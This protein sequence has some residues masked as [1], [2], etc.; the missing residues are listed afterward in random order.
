MDM[1]MD[2]K[3]IRLYFAVVDKEF[4]NGNY[5]TIHRVK[6]NEVSATERPKTYIIDKTDMRKADYRQR[7]SKDNMGVVDKYSGVCYHT[8][9]EELIELYDKHLHKKIIE[10]ENKRNDALNMIDSLYEGE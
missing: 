7:V 8:N 3:K 6:I 4:V 1:D 2:V 9:K 5:G 10:L